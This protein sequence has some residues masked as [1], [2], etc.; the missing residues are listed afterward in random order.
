MGVR[1]D[2]YFFRFRNFWVMEGEI[3]FFGEVC[4][5]RGVVKVRR[6]VIFFSESIFSRKF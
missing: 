5:G 2:K 6:E 1:E 4:R 3:V